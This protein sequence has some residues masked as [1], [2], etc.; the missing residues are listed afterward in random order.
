MRDDP[1][2]G[3]QE[4]GDQLQDPAGAE[5][6]PEER[7]GGADRRGAAE[8]P[9]QRQ[10][11]RR[12]V[13]F[14]SGP[15]RVDVVDIG[16]AQSA[17]V[18]RRGH[19]PLAPG[20]VRV[21]RRRMPRVAGES[22]A[23]DPGERRPASGH[24]QIAALEHDDSR[25]LTE[26]EARRIGERGGLAGGDHPQRIESRHHRAGHRVGTAGDDQVQ[27][28]PAD[29]IGAD[30]DGGVRAGASRGDRQH[31][32]S[33]AAHALDH[34]RA[35]RDQ[36]RR[37]LP[38]AYPLPLVAQDVPGDLFGTH[39]PAVRAAQTDADPL[40]IE[41]PGVHAGVTNRLPIRLDGQQRGAVHPRPRFRIRLDRHVL[42][43]AARQLADKTACIDVGH[44]RDGVAALEQGPSHLGA[45]TSQRREGAHADDDRLVAGMRNRTRFVRLASQRTLANASRGADRPLA[46]AAPRESV[47]IPS[48]AGAGGEACAASA[49]KV[50]RECLVHRRN[51][52]ST[53]WTV[54]LQ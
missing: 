15:V 45:A 37:D 29:E 17:V 24:L 32:A 19:R 53:R 42:A 34:G 44:L 47:R 14:R 40:R 33:G 9:A 43:E 2:T 39:E 26:V 30:A 10:G 20:A 7:L 23:Q 50:A 1:V 49:G 5:R 22:V 12:V 8:D 28:A 38:A 48:C 31:P 51:P 35:V 16:G 41:V 27:L 3:E 21:R 52:P 18:E 13:G 54:P 6:V 46:R 25:T 4:G 36:R 11:F